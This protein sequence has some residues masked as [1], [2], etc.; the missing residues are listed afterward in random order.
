MLARVTPDRWARVKEI[1]N[2]ALER[3]A[4]ERAG[5]VSAEAGD[6]PLVIAEVERLL[7][8][9]EQ[10]GGFIEQTPIAGGAF[11]PMRR[12]GHYEIRSTL[13]AGAMGEVYRAHDTTLNRD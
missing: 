6:D 8:A 3:T 5:G 7:A 4:V 10:L 1:F 13:G 11:M 12:L 9:H 2:S